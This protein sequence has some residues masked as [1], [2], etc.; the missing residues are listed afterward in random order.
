[1][2]WSELR[3]GDESHLTRFSFLCKKSGQ[4]QCRLFFVES[5]TVEYRRVPLK[6]KFIRIGKSRTRITRGLQLIGRFLFIHLMLA[7][8]G[9]RLGWGSISADA[10]SWLVLFVCF[11]DCLNKRWRLT[12]WQRKIQLRGWGYTS[13]RLRIRCDRFLQKSDA[14]LSFAGSSTRWTRRARRPPNTAQF[15]RRWRQIQYIFEFQTTRHHPD[16]LLTGRQKFYSLLTCY[17]IAAADLGNLRI[18]TTN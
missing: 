10:D 1:M 18:I 11:N 14:C 3:H 16:F 4:E 5:Q 15:D 6:A 12:N 17:T 8:R 9:R 2:E 7:V 13:A